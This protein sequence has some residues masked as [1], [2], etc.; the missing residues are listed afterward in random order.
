MKPSE[1]SETD[2][3]AG[4]RGGVPL[5]TVRMTRTEGEGVLVATVW[6]HSARPA[7]ATVGARL[8][9]KLESTTLA[10]APAGCSA[11][12]A[13]LRCVTCAQPGV[14]ARSASIS[15]TR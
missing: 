6:F 1:T 10:A 4:K 12:P 15:S 13:L 14:S 3:F 7:M 8:A 11:E 9:A 5:S 2:R